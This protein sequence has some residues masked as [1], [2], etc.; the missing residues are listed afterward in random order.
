MSFIANGPDSEISAEDFK[1]KV[2][3]VRST[4]AQA[5]KSNLISLVYDGL[6]N[7]WRM[8]RLATLARV[9]PVIVRFLSKDDARGIADIAS[10]TLDYF[11]DPTVKASVQKIAT[12]LTPPN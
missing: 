1:T 11:S 3:E 8:S 6:S 7:D 2:T 10:Q 12:A 9:S 5:M 4:F